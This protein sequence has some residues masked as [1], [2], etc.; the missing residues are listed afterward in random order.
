MRKLRAKDLP[1]VTKKIAEVGVWTKNAGFFFL[2]LW[3][4]VIKFSSLNHSFLPFFLLAAPQIQRITPAKCS[5]EHRELCPISWDRTFWG[6]MIWGKECLYKYDSLCCS[7]IANQ[8]HFNNNKKTQTK[9]KQKKP[10]VICF[11]NAFGYFEVLAFWQGWK[12]LQDKM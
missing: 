4:P 10:K 11:K 1:K 5:V 3:L 8:L 2:F 7:S 9:P 6:M 12:E